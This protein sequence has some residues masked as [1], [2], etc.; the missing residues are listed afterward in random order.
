V[1]EMMTSNTLLYVPQNK[2]EATKIK[3]IVSKINTTLQ[4]I[5]NTDEHKL[6]VSLNE[7]LK[8]YSVYPIHKIVLGMKSDVLKNEFQKSNWLL[9]DHEEV[10]DQFLDYIYTGDVKFSVEN[11]LGLL[12]WSNKFEVKELKANVEKFLDKVLDKTTV[13]KLLK[14]SLQYDKLLFGENEDF[15]KKCVSYIIKEFVEM[16]KTPKEFTQLPFD[17]LFT[18]ITS[19]ELNIESD[20]YSVY[21][22]VMEYIKYVDTLQMDQKVQLLNLIPAVPIHQSTKM[23]I[24]AKD[25]GAE[26][27]KNVIL[28]RNLDENMDLTFLT[29]QEFMDLMHKPNLNITS[30][31]ALY[32]IIKKHISL[33]QGFTEEDI[34]KLKKLIQLEWMNESELQEVISDGFIPP[35]LVSESIFN[36]FCGK[37]Y[38]GPKLSYCRKVSISIAGEIEKDKCRVLLTKNRIARYVPA[39]V[40]IVTSTTEKEFVTYTTNTRSAWSN[41]LAVPFTTD[42]PYV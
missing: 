33:I 37:L 19:S 17:I 2:N 32:T 9:V 13:I 20:E 41:Y 42:K 15:K 34:L 10:L 3:S 29:K 24:L 16:S 21:R 18:M 25:Y 14:Q 1:T 38:R 23:L 31:F 35:Q 26:K 40:C 28:A 11:A 7:E 12:Y 5:E 6:L 36:V 27:L 8:K 30:E 22:V 4:Q 39:K